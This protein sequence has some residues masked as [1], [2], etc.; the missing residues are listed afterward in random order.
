MKQ[1]NQKHANRHTWPRK[2]DS[3][4]LRV[5]GVNVAPGAG[6]KPPRRLVWATVVNHS[7]TYPYAAVKRGGTAS[8]ATYYGR[9]D[10]VAAG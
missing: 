7:K 1:N 6:H 10:I 5:L 3:Q 2:P 4:R 9:G 8:F